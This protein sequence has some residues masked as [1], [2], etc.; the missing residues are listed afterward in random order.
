MGGFNAFAVE[1]FAGLGPVRLRKMFGGAGLYLHDVMFALIDK[2][3]IYLKT[4]EALAKALTTEGA[5]PWIYEK[6]PAAKHTYFSLPLDAMDDPEA[7]ARWGRRA[8]EIAAAL[9]K[10]NPKR[11]AA[12]R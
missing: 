10:P 9:K 7:A 5:D 3:V 2:D 6:N 12:K 8:Y 4:D 11:R 1:L